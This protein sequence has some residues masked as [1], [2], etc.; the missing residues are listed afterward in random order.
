MGKIGNYIIQ[1]RRY[2]LAKKLDKDFDILLYE[3]DNESN[4]KLDKSIIIWI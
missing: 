4:N 3:I 2:L 1:W